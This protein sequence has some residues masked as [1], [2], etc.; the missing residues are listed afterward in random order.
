VRGGV[1][2]ERALLAWPA[3]RWVALLGACVFILGRFH[4]PIDGEHYFRQTHVAANIEKFVET[5]L[6][7]RPQTYNRDAP[8]AL[9]DFPAYEVAIA[10][11]CRS[12][13]GHPLE[14]ARSLNLGLFVLSFL[15]LDSLLAR[16]GVPPLPRLLALVF[17]AFA[18]A[19]L[20]Y[21]GTPLPDSLALAASLVSLLAFVRWEEGGGVPM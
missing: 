2:E 15:L 19:N 6:S 3:A 13:G 4:A 10:F 18:P 12:F 8:V 5:G 7:L 17:F 1:A 11:V 16:T 20:Y 21:M 9:F 14:T